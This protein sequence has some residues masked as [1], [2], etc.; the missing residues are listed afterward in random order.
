MAMDS[1]SQSARF[2]RRA[3]L[4]AITTGVCSS[5]GCV[6]RARS[7]INRGSP[8]QVF[9]EIKSVP[10]DSDPSSV[11]ISRYLAEK[12]E[13]VGANVEVTLLETNELY[14]EILI[15]QEFDLAVVSHPG[16]RDPDFLRPLL[17]SR[18]SEEPGWQNPWGLTDLT[19]DE[20][21]DDQIDQQ[22]DQ[23][24]STIHELV[25]EI[26]RKQP[27]TPI[28]FNNF[29]RSYREEKFS[30]WHTASLNSIFLYLSLT[31]TS[32]EPT[33]QNQNALS[34]VLT[35]DR[36]T[37]NFNPLSVEYRDLGTFTDLVYDSLLRFND[38]EPVPWIAESL[39]WDTTPTG[40]TS[41]ITI[42]DGIEWH[43]GERLT[44]DDIA[45]TYDFL[46][47]TT[48]DQHEIAVPAP[49]Y[50]GEVSLVET[51]ETTDESTVTISFGSQNRQVCE[52][53]LTVPI[54]PA[55]E[56]TDKSALANIAGIE[57]LQGTTEAL[58]WDNMSPVGSG[59][60]RVTGSQTDQWLEMTRFDNH[61]LTDEPANIDAQF[62]GGPSFERLRME[63]APSYEAALE[64]LRTGE[65][66]VIGDEL[67]Y[68]LVPQI[69]EADTL[70]LKVDRSPSF[71]AI[72]FNTASGPLSNPHFRRA[73]A[74][75]LDKQ[76]IA[77]VIFGGF[78]DPTADPIRDETWSPS[79]FEWNGTDP[80][81]PFAGEHG[82]LNVE[83]AKSNFADAGYQYGGEGKLLSR[84][85]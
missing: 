66:D 74:Q 16:G 7:L 19:I 68:E 41:T 11:Q 53:P 18:F 70:Q 10:A 46:G 21:L 5:T 52:Q 3:V 82:D 51:V 33:E 26:S 20:L 81:V 31:P 25:R 78:A 2:S 1:E 63:V 29:I 79:E 83:A 69:G 36:V 28:V 50:R 75:L 49:Q 17:H 61:F 60:F 54:L 30:G 38:H 15:N 34:V 24:R 65:G 55:H 62:H 4:G 13:A 23:R 47:D 67:N 27:F 32:I 64:L 59:I 39:E 6:K 77:D 57:L 37:N 56:W 35:D 44:P 12:L 45:F 22:G 73:V 71:Y 14:Q 9:L 40:L 72:G 48:L 76:F 43:D 58:V 85:E 80:A 42:R 8:E 84:T